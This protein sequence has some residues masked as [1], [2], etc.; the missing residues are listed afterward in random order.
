[1]RSLY[2]PSLLLATIL[3]LSVPGRLTSPVESAPRPNA[4]FAGGVIGVSD[5]IQTGYDSYYVGG[6][7]ISWVQTQL[8]DVPSLSNSPLATFFFLNTGSNSGCSGFMQ[9][10]LQ[11]LSGT[12]SEV[13][14]NGF[15]GCIVQ[16]DPV[17]LASQSVAG[18]DLLLLTENQGGG[19]GKT[20]YSI[21]DLNNQNIAYVTVTN[22]G[23]WGDNLFETMTETHANAVSIGSFKYDGSSFGN[24]SGSAVSVQ[25]GSN[26][27]TTPSLYGGACTTN[28]YTLG[29]WD[30]SY[31]G[32][33]EGSVSPR[34][35][36]AYNY[37]GAGGTGGVVVNP[38]NIEGGPDNLL[39]EMTAPNGG[40]WSYIETDF[41]QGFTGTISIDGYSYNNNGGA[42]YS[43]VI[44]SVYDPFS[45]SWSKI[46]DVNC[47]PNANPP[48]NCPWNP[49]NNN[50]PAWVSVGTVTQFPVE[51]MNITV[52][53]NTGYSG[54]LYIDA[55]SISG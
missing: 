19:T 18:H 21:E 33:Q 43:H 23:T 11:F 54:R 26:Q 1:M 16:S 10:G 6:G 15:N 51:D 35:Y 52:V 2:F 32:Y 37:L 27:V 39:T 40:T 53:D 9:N 44:V 31:A 46:Y 47:A 38:S 22:I 25:T 36:C 17:Q 28:V 30:N 14:M 12:F 8:L 42:Y 4:Q 45:E 34:G 29:S 24:P 49:S 20:T 5:S 50:S 41:G 55:V 3:L 13:Y 7:T 48:P